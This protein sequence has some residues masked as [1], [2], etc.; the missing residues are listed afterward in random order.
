[1]AEY[2]MTNNVRIIFNCFSVVDA[3]AEVVNRQS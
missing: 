3:C 2:P 1:M